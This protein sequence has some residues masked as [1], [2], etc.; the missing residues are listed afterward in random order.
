[1][2]KFQQLVA[3]YKAG[4]DQLAPAIDGLSYKELNAHPVPG[5]WSI[6]QIVIHM[7]D[8]DLIASDRMKRV[9]AEDQPALIGYNETLF[10]ENLPQDQLDAA[11]ACEIFRLNRLLTA[12]LLEHVPDKAFA[13]T[14][15]HNEVGPVTLEK[16][17]TT[18]TNHLTHHMRF[19]REKRKLLGK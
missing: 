1:M 8:S 5:T 17:L 3:D 16:L 4:A 13:R 14:G 9:I 6:Q 12:A 18:Y 7:M 11:M 2:S 10:A 15:I 19:A